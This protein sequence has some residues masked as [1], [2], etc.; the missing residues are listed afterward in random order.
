[1]WVV[2]IIPNVTCFINRFVNNPYRMHHTDTSHVCEKQQLHHK[3]SE[4]SNTQQTDNLCFFRCLALYRVCC[5]MRLESS[6]KKLYDDHNED[7]VDIRRLS[8][9]TLEELDRVEVVCRTNNRVYKSLEMKNGKTE[10]KLVRSSLCRYPETLNVNLA[11][12]HILFVHLKHKQIMQNFLM[13]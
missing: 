12:M 2:E 3:H 6:V 7:R 4:R 8:G 11:D 13:R 10:A 9:V 5:L 1:M